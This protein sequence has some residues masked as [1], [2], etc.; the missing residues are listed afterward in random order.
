[1]LSHEPCLKHF[2][3]KALTLGVTINYSEGFS[4]LVLDMV[5]DLW[6]D[7]IVYLSDNLSVTGAKFRIY[8]SF[9]CIGFQYH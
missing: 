5:I 7:A 2:I 1:M 9:G 8:P 3:K 6:Y 4:L